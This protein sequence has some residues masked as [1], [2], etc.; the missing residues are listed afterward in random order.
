MLTLISDPINTKRRRTKKNIQKQTGKKHKKYLECTG[1]I[2]QTMKKMPFC[3]VKVHFFICK[4]NRLLNIF[5]LLQIKQHIAS[6]DYVFRT[7]PINCNFEHEQN[8][9]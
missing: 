5:S 3:K 7:I 2:N 8:V 6:S 4:S 9:V 1:V